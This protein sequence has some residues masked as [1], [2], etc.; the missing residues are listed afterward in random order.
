MDLLERRFVNGRENP[1]SCI[2]LTAHW[3]DGWKFKDGKWKFEEEE[4]L[5][6]VGE[7]WF[8][9]RVNLYTSREARIT[10]DLIQDSLQLISSSFQLNG[11]LAQFNGGLLTVTIP[12][13]LDWEETENESVNPKIFRYFESLRLPLGA[14][15]FF[16][17]QVLITYRN[18]GKLFGSKRM[19]V[20]E[21]GRRGY[22]W[23]GS[24]RPGSQWVHA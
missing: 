24:V 5:P 23:I 13:K 9:C 20:D 16:N 15:A 8:R 10:Q 1:E 17:L 12:L 6:H 3:A 7:G 22:R 18:L 11:V 2:Q 4:Q 21:P 19:F 14:D